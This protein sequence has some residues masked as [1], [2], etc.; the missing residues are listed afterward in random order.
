MPSIVLK[1]ILLMSPATGEVKASS[2]RTVEGD[3]VV[4]DRN[5]STVR[6]RI[7]EEVFFASAKDFKNRSHGFIYVV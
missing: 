1:K 4:L 2:T 6:F 5:R 7:G 3:I